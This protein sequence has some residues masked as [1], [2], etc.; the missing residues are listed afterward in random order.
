M[1][2]KY[3]KLKQSLVYT[4]IILLIIKE[5]FAQKCRATAFSHLF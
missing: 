3:E 2:R 5:D 1:S 4:Y